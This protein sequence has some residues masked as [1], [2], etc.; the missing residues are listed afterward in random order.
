MTGAV[1]PSSR[2]G[3]VVP[4]RSFVGAK[5][6]LAGHLDEH[7]RAAAL[8]Q[9]A[10]RVV[11]A[12][13]PMKVLVVTSASEV[14]AWASE[15]GV[16]VVDDPGSLDGAAT[17]GTRHLLTAGHVRAVIAHADLP[18]AQS[19]APLATDAGDPVVALVPCHRDDGT[20]VLSVPTGLGF[21]FAYGP[22]SFHRH[23]A[24]ASRLG[25]EARIV[26]APDLVVDVDVPDDLRYLRSSSPV[27]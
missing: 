8:R 6:R 14:R 20:N 17:V 22:G 16:E 23:L 24:E 9:M 13:S 25:V 27:R 21:R 26:R 3:V 15:R 1:A 19:L 12:A 11:D 7:A 10:D 4:I 5:A 2:V 18:R